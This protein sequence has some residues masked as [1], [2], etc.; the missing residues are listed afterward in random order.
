MGKRGNLLIW[1]HFLVVWLLPWI[2]YTALLV[3]RLVPLWSG[4]FLPFLVALVY[5]RYTHSA[6]SLPKY[7]LVSL[8][9]F[10]LY[11]GIS[12]EF[13]RYNLSSVD[14]PIIAILVIIVIV[15]L[16]FRGRRS[17]ISY[18]GTDERVLGAMTYIY[19]I[20]Y[21][22]WIYWLLY[23]DFID[24]RAFMLYLIGYAIFIFSIYFLQISGLAF[25]LPLERISFEP[26]MFIGTIGNP[27]TFNL[28]LLIAAALGTFASY[29]VLNDTRVI[30]IFSVLALLLITYNVKRSVIVGGVVYFTLLPLF[31]FWE[32]RFSFIWVVA[33]YIILLLVT[34]ILFNKKPL[35][36]IVESIKRNLFTLIYPIKLKS[37]NVHPQI[38]YFIIGASTTR[39]WLTISGLKTW[40]SS[41]IWGV[42]FECVRRY[43][44]FNRAYETYYAEHTKGYDRS[45]N[46]YIDI[47]IEGG[48]IWLASVILLMFPVFQVIKGYYAS[49][50]IVFIVMIVL[51]FLFWDIVFLMATT[52]L[53]GYSMYVEG[54]FGVFTIRIYWLLPLLVLLLVVLITSLF[55]HLSNMYKGLVRSLWTKREWLSTLETYSVVLGTYPFEDHSVVQSLDI[56]VK[57]IQVLE[58]KKTSLN[59]LVRLS[60]RTV[61][62]EDYI[63]ITNYP[64]T[65][66]GIIAYAYG[67]LH[68]LGCKECIDRAIDFFERS[69]AINPFNET[70]IILYAKLMG[71]LGR[72]DDVID[73]LEKIIIPKYTNDPLKFVEELKNAMTDALN[74]RERFVGV[75]NKITNLDEYVKTIL[76]DRTSLI[77]SDILKM[78]IYALIQQKR[79]VDAK[80]WLALYESL[81]K[82]ADLAFIDEMFLKVKLGQLRNI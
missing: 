60:T 78:Y 61:E 64:D 12:T 10:S 1:K 6:F 56:V 62:Y 46:M 70:V 68:I 41:P 11:A 16:A 71:N 75:K 44:M 76:A 34:W 52:Y 63:D 39:I 18:F 36:K 67:I 26:G 14:V 54:L 47:L 13:F 66:L 27:L 51:L 5:S 74:H 38:K 35:S 37:L 57:Y 20:L 22:V 65:L 40:L 17:W 59:E 7:T 58:A 79:F 9:I 53:V 23:Y 19:M 80:G 32:F 55:R 72:W 50:I 69:I 82:D 45:H 4:L 29:F 30:W 31:L 15:A 25:R 28:N 48:I 2:M 33:Y 24:T 81:Y 8:Y 43:L 73:I 21:S 77:S 49:S 42:G 3:L